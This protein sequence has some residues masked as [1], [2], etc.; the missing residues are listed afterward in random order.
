MK[1]GC[2][3]SA[4]SGH[5]DFWPYLTSTP[6]IDSDHPMVREYA[7]RA[8]SGATDL[9]ERG[10]GCVQRHA[11]QGQADKIGFAGVATDWKREICSDQVKD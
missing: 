7:R 4:G 5:E 10:L 1:I 11:H 6:I 8:A 2:K 9:K 3:P